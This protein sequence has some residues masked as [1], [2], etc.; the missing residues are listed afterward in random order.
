MQRSLGI[1]A[2]FFALA[3]LSK[4]PGIFPFLG[5]LI[6]LVVRDRLKKIG[7]RES[8]YRAAFFAGLTAL[9]FLAILWL[10]DIFWTGFTDPISHLLKMQGESLS[11]TADRPEGIASLPWQWLVNEVKI[12]YFRVDIAVK[13]GER[14]VSSFIKI[15]FS[16]EFNW[17]LLF[18]LVP[19]IGY[20]AYDPRRGRNEL[21][22]M[23]II[24]FAAA[25]LPYYPLH[26]FAHRIMYIFYLVPAVPP[27]ALA[28]SRLIGRDGLPDIIPV[29]FTVAYL[30]IFAMQFPFRVIP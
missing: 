14:V 1:S 6:Y 28:I 12:P 30:F 17:M 11:L 21:S 3:A 16:G 23:A 9:S 26:F 27:L 20:A 10:L 8:L 25:Y 19:S 4:L 15:F 5:A 18:A 13:E 22:I 24:W 2:V 29:T 7:I